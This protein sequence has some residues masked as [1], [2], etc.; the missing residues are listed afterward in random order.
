M[1]TDRLLSW[2][3]ES[4]TFRLGVENPSPLHHPLPAAIVIASVVNP[5]D[6]ATTTS[7]QQ[8]EA[9]F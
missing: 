3:I 9:V 7:L 8:Q 5:F 4:S 1:P 2:I 6:I